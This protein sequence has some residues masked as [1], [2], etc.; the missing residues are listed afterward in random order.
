ME[1]KKKEARKNGT[2]QILGKGDAM[3]H[4]D[5]LKAVMHYEPYDRIPVVSFG[6]WEE[7]LQKWKAEGYPL[8]DPVFDR[9]MDDHEYEQINRQ[10]GFD[11][12]WHTETGVPFGLLK[13]AF[14]RTVLEVYP[15]G[16]QKIRDTD[17]A[18]VLVR[19]G[20]ASIPKEVGH[21][22]TDRASWEEFYLPRLTYG[23][24][25]LDLALFEQL[26]AQNH[27]REY[28]L[29]LFCGSMFGRM[30]NW[31]GLENFIYLWEDDEELFTDIVNAVGD[32]LY[33]RTK[34][35]LETGVR[36]DYAHFWE[37]MC[38]N[39]GPLVKMSVMREIAGPHYRRITDLLH[40]YGIDIV[41]VDCDGRIDQMIPV[42]I[43]NG[44]NTMFPMEIGTWQANI[45][46]WRKQY[47]K[48]ILGVG[49]VDKR[50]F[51]M[52]YA[53]IDKE[54]DRIRPFVEQGGYIPCPDHRIPP[55][56]KWENVQYYCDRLRQVFSK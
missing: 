6:F 15:D 34:D 41:S 16:K 18:I 36:F 28:P 56:A 49:G 29:G 13:P 55:D 24:E 21:T 12:N 38:G 53:A 9:Y 37:D 5:R 2:E 20:H 27:T 14:E 33:A 30:R 48:K 45:G 47:G 25:K 3:N 39:N 40:Q 23:R 7:T 31:L 44:V 46:A 10:L 26:K 54:I 51:A 1:R 17:G 52:D 32:L 50:I 19:P 11:Y 4:R 43:E 8:R 35:I 22:L 42:W